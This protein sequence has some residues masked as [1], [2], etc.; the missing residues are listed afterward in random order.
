MDRLAT[1]ILAASAVGIAAT[2]TSG[3]VLSLR[4][5]AFTASLDEATR[6]DR[7]DEGSTTPLDSICLGLAVFE[8]EASIA[9]E[10]DPKSASENISTFVSPAMSPTSGEEVAVDDFG[11]LMAP[12][13]STGLDGGMPLSSQSD[14]IKG[15]PSTSE[16]ESGGFAPPTSGTFDDGRS[17]SS[18]PR[19]GSNGTAG[20]DLTPISV[21][22][23]GI[24]A[25]ASLAIARF[26]RRR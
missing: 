20:T 2:A 9:F 22:G 16:S 25:L 8:R 11:D 1:T 19:I 13:S 17:V 4:D 15:M 6:W 7:I 23:S 10:L 18:G 3:S 5:Q 24:A 14:G 12:S 21:P 26:R